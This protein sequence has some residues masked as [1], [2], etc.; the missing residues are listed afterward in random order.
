MFESAR[1]N[2]F[3]GFELIEASAEGAQIEMAVRDDSI[4]ETGVVQ[5]GILS[6]LADTTAVYAL[7][8]GFPRERT[9]AGVEFKMNFLRPALPEAGDLRARASVVRRGGTLGICRVE[10]EQAGR[11]IAT[12]LFTYIFSPR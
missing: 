5:G 4:Q 10:L 1:V 2:A 11:A 9:I 12:G 8:H 3:L 7:A 6:A